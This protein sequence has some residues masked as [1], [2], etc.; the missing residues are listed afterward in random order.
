[1]CLSHADEKSVHG[2][3]YNLGLLMSYRFSR[4]QRLKTNDFRNVLRRMVPI[5][6]TSTQRSTTNRGSQTAPSIKYKVVSP[7]C[8]V[9]V[10]RNTL[11]YPRLGIS[12][13]KHIGTAPHRN[14]IKRLI[15]ETFRL[16][17]DALTTPVDMVVVV[18]RDC[19]AET[20]HD[21]SYELHSVWKQ[22]G[23]L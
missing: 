15:R 18:R 14:R 4:T 7:H 12:V 16:S 9:Y 3:P 10:K 17:Q 8:V 11:S 22:C 23:I 2:L 21:I 6:A 19:A 5:Q 13:P 1:M 20:Q